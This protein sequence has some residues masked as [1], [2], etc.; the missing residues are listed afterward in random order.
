[1]IY[2]VLL[3]L[4]ALGQIG[5]ISFLHQEV[6]GY[7]YEIVYAGFI[8]VLSYRYRL[9]PFRD[10][11]KFAPLSGAFAFW[12][13]ITYLISLPRYAPIQN[14]IALLYL[15][16][17]LF[18]FGS[19]FVLRHHLALR[20]HERGLMHRALAVYCAI[21]LFISVAQYV[22]YPNLRNLTYLGWDP[23][24]FRIFG[25]VLDTSIAAAL[26]G[27][28]IIHLIFRERFER[29]LVIPVFIA[30][31]FTYARGYFV[32]L[33]VTLGY[34]AA[35]SKLILQYVAFITIVTSTILMLPQPGGEGVNLRRTAS[36]MS[37]VTDFETAVDIWK[38]R[39]VI[40]IGY[41]HI[42]Y[43]RRYYE[44]PAAQTTQDV[45]H[46][47][48]SFHSSYLI[49]LVTSGIVGLV[50]FVGMLAQLAVVSPVASYMTLFLG[51]YSLSDNV[52]L[53]PFVLFLYT[54][55]MAYEMV[56]RKR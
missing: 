25:T 40:G 21:A 6:N 3:L 20:S 37:R 5:R 1:M 49:I 28:I 32:A 53:H 10:L 47:G 44:A 26:F 14:G 15:L 9:T 18:Y 56:V 27:L 4:F 29:F 50:L 13:A 34:Y 55:L 38:E 35:R 7:L 23:H 43:E 19:M 39:P 2:T 54:V 42:R 11:R 48:A 31:L 8:A 16:R 46:A 12:L 41:N 36:I 30:S 52:L 45:S 51:V 33:F 24:Q 17:L 22:F